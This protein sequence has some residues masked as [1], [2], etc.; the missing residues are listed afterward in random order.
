[1]QESDIDYAKLDS[2]RAALAGAR[3]QVIRAESA[4]RSATAQ[5]EKLEVQINDNTLRAPIRA[6]VR[7]R[8]AEPGEVLASG[9]KVLVLDDLSDVYMYVFLPAGAAGRVALGSE[10]RIV[11]DA[12]PEYPIRA[13]I[14][15]VSPIAQF[16]PK[17][18]ETAEVRH[19]LSFR[20]KLQI[21]RNRLRQY[22]RFVKVGV[23]G[24]G[25][26]RYDESAQ[27]PTA[28]QLKPLPNIRWS[29]PGSVLH[30]D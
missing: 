17:T 19:N 22:E 9:G 26:V 13:Q 5:A 11:L 14:T 23:P 18:V 8:L 27:W 2:A 25:Y 21:D 1:M 15:Y 10:A 20:V 30:R 29:G 12:I 16:T 7:N 4:I 28:L 3:A 6:R 24:M